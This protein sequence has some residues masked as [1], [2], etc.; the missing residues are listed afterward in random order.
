VTRR[1]K[2]VLTA[3][4]LLQMVLPLAAPMQL[5][6]LYDLFG[7][8]VHRSGPPSPASLT[9]P[10]ISEATTSE[11]SGVPLATPVASF[12]GPASSSPALVSACASFAFDSRLVSAPLTQRT[13]LRI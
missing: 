10:A 7:T 6:E 9:T 11:N 4:F 8:Q 1:F 3:L 13:V 2:R 5:I 12:G